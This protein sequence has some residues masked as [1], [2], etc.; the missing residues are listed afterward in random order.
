[1]W[2]EGLKFHSKHNCADILGNSLNV[3]QAKVPQQ[4]IGYL[5]VGEQGLNILYPKCITYYICLVFV[6][7][8]I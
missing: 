5:T 6:T 3:N 1:M 2:E 4:L 7:V 8:W